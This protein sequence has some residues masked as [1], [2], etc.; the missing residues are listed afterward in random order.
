MTLATTREDMI[1]ATME[2]I[3]YDLKD[4]LEAMLKADIP[5]FDTVR[6][7]GGIAASEIWNQMQADI[8]GWNVETVEV[9]EATALGCAIV[10]A[11]GAEVY[12]NYQEAVDH[13]VRIKKRYTPTAKVHELYKDAYSVWKTIFKHTHGACNDEISRFQDKYRNLI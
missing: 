1:R 12:R 3:T 10:A 6:I 7:T 9:N 4:M 5:P 13:M 2:G 11:V 8:Y